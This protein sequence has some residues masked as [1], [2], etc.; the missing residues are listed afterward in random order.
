V[1]DAK[2]QISCSSKELNKEI[3]LYFIIK[4]YNYY[5]TEWT[6]LMFSMI[7]FHHSKYL[8]IEHYIWVC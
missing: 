7:E 3:T 6:F 8:F 4:K 1:Q 5:I 2:T